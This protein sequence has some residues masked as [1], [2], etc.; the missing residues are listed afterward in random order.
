MDTDDVTHTLRNG[1]VFKALGEEHQCAVLNDPFSIN[2]RVG[3]CDAHLANES[4]RLE[5]L[6]RE[7][8]IEDN[9]VEVPLLVR[10]N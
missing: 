7:G 10:A 6:V 8:C 3:V 2:L 5:G 1:E 9:S 4:T